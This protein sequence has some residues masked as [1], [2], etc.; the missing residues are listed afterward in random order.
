VRSEVHSQLEHLGRLEL[1]H[2]HHLLEIAEPEAH[3]PCDGLGCVSSE[4][5]V[6][7]SDH[8]EQLDGGWSQVLHLVH[9]HEVDGCA[10][11]PQALDLSQDVVDDVHEVEAPYL[12]LP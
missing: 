7:L 9:K 6:L 12:L 1:I 3:S 11:V 2:V 8:Q 5:N 4:V 10:E